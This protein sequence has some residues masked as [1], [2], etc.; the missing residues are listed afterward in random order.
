[1]FQK[2]ILVLVAWLC[3]F[4]NIYQILYLKWVK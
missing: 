2:L 3:I 4:T 1:M